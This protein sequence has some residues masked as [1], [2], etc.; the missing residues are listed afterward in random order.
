MTRRLLFLAAT[1][2]AACGPPVPGQDG[3]LDAGAPDAGKSDAGGGIL[4]TTCFSNMKWMLGTTGSEGMNPGYAC[5]SCHLGQ[6]FMGQNPAGVSNPQFAMFF[7]GTVYSDFNE[8]DL[9]IASGIPAGTVVEILDSNNVLK[10]TLPVDPSGNF[11]STEVDAPFPLPY[12]ARVRSNGQ[13]RSM[14]DTQV[15]GDCNSCHTEQGRALAPGRII[16]P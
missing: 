10:L 5:R 3:G 14:G 7:M 9:C 2:L 15:N 13:V 16:V 4:P 11:R 8:Q 1:T 12:R 6:N